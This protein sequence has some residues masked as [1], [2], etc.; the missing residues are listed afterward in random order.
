MVPWQIGLILAVGNLLILSVV[1][2]LIGFVI[3]LVMKT[4]YRLSWYLK[5]LGIAI[6]MVSIALV[7]VHFTRARIS[8]YWLLLSGLLGAFLYQFG[9]SRT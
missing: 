9:A 3:S 1:V 5:D 8:E 2:G 4:G 7:L 6:A